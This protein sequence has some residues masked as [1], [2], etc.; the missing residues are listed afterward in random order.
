MDNST[1]QYICHKLRVDDQSKVEIETKKRLTSTSATSLKKYLDKKDQVKHIKSTTF[2]DQFLDTPEFDLF[3][4][5]ASLRIR[6]KGYGSNVYL[7]Y[8]G[9][10]FL[11]KGILFRSEFSSGSIKELVIEESHHDIIHFVGIDLKHIMKNYLPKEMS[12][13]M[14]DHIGPS[15]INRIKT[16]P[17]ICFYHKEKYIIKFG[18]V[19]LEPSLDHISAFHINKDTFHSL[20][21]FWEYE[22]EIK[23]KDKDLKNKILNI[24]KILKFDS[25]LSKKFLMQTEVMDKYHRVLSC[26]M[27]IKPD[28]LATFTDPLESL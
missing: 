8:K 14:I 16:A 10:G 4:S 2:I 28:C 26:F 12:S 25:T 1:I 6:Y 5:G 7:Q 17:I 23:S 21:N 19:S 11:H 9:H 18:N 22:N 3:Y 15:I 24:N 13:V 27:H 20:S